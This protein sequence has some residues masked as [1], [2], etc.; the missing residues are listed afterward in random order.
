MVASGTIA[1]SG[2][3]YTSNRMTTTSAIV[4]SSVL[5]VPLTIAFM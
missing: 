3:R 2:A 1:A 4:T 5:S